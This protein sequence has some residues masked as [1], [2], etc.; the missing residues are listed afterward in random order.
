MAQGKN[1]RS[2]KTKKGKPV[3]II[4][5]GGKFFT[6]KYCGKKAKVLHTLSTHYAEVHP[7]AINR[8]PKRDGPTLGQLSKRGILK[9]TTDAEVAGGLVVAKILRDPYE[10]RKLARELIDE[11]VKRRRSRGF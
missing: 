10:S 6:C 2:K 5:K 11:H 7:H 3:G 4:R 1:P 9:G 8:K